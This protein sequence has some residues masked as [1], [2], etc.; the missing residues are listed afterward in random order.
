MIQTYNTTVRQ[1]G[2]K[3]VAQCL[4][5]ELVGEGNTREEALMDLRESLLLHFE[6]LRPFIKIY[7]NTVEQE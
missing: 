6:E 2:D 3:F 4:E 7:L 5:I 1:E